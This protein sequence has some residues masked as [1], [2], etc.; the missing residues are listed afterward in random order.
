MLV[1]VVHVV[2]LKC[3]EAESIANKPYTLKS[4]QGGCWKYKLCINKAVQIVC[5]SY[6]FSQSDKKQAFI[7]WWLRS[8]G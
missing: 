1:F 6:T 5:S 7:G 2:G 8:H 3:I 4:F